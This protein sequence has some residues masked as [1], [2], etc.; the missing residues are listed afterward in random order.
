MKKL[1]TK[2]FI[3][4]DITL[5]CEKVKTYKESAIISLTF[6][7]LGI[8]WILFSDS[9]L[10]FLIEDD[11][12]IHTIHTFKGII[13]VIIT[14]IFLFFITSKRVKLLKEALI[15]IGANYD[16]AIEI[17]EQLIKAQ[18]ELTV[19]NKQLQENRNALMV[20]ELRFQ[21]A[22]E[23]AN[24][25]IWDWDIIRDIYYFSLRK[26]MNKNIDEQDNI[27]RKVWEKLVHPEDRETAVRNLDEFLL[28]KDDIYQS[29]YRLIINDQYYW[30]LSKG[31]LHRDQYGKPIRM[32]GSHTDITKQI[33][34]QQ[35]LHKL[36]YFDS[37]T[38]LPNR[39]M[40]K[41]TFTHLLEKYN[42]VYV[43]YID[44]DNFK[45]VNNTLG[46]IEGDKLLVEF[47]RRIELLV[48]KSHGIARLGGDEFLLT[49]P[50]DTDIE[51]YINAL[52]EKIQEPFIL[53]C[54]EFYITFS[55]GIALYPEN[56]EDFDA[57]LKN[58]DTAMSYAKSSGKDKYRY[59]DMIMEIE[60]IEHMI[61]VKELRKAVVNEDFEL[62]YQPIFD[63]N[64][65]SLIGV[66]ALIRWFHPT[67]GN[68][69]PN[70]FIPIAEEAGYIRDITKW[71]FVTA[72]KQRKYWMER[73]G[74]D[75]LISINISGLDLSQEHLLEY[76]ETN[77]YEHFPLTGVQLEITE[78]AV[79]NNLDNAINI[80]NDLKKKGMTIALD[81]FG[82]GYSSLTYLRKLP[83]DVLKVDR[84]FIKNIPQENTEESIVENVIK[85][86]HDINLKVIAE[87]I[88]N[89]EQI[90]FLKK[91]GCDW[92]QGYLLSKPMNKEKITEFIS[93]YK[94]T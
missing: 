5:I 94:T 13:F 76:I 28:G 17:N 35:Q 55:M 4:L 1:R 74:I 32:A 10:E 54:Q 36:A 82:K 19:Q 11:E 64:S 38:D 41:E 69:A 77:C 53:D 86:A 56:G 33:E 62:Y 16:D 59:Y 14:G 3:P 44:I 15:A 58:A 25:G 81:D 60:S 20:S 7:F 75:L 88:E 71:V 70:Y 2:Y 40:M 89:P 18:K 27:S 87:G 43:L 66:E 67:K 9:I 22:T 30:I 8:I 24:D 85:L 31:K 91:Y 23:G 61:M 46:H 73:F 34:N 80:I 51:D 49:I 29:T 12:L 93:L 84:E 83:I 92:G 21:L 57:L 42:N 45:D 78:T 50:G 39:I 47:A 68:I 6:V 72:C 63:L 26:K 90:N 37:L 48:E 65:R 79:M 52:K